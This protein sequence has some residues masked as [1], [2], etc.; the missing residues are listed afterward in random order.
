MSKERRFLAIQ[1][2]NS[3]NLESIFLISSADKAINELAAVF[4]ACHFD[5]PAIRLATAASKSP[6]LT[7]SS[8]K[9]NPFFGLLSS[10]N[11]GALIDT[12]RKSVFLISVLIL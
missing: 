1:I 12:N 6:F 4:K 7:V 9:I 10:I 2:D 5:V 8:L 3:Y 11:S